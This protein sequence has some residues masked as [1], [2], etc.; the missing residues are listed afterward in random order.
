MAPSTA[1]AQNLRLDRVV[2]RVEPLAS[3]R[4]HVRS[5]RV[6]ASIGSKKSLSPTIY[7]NV[8]LYTG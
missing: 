8:V 2:L 5:R 4:P 6:R 3:E 7:T 1:A